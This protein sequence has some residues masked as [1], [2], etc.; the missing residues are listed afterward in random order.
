MGL[1]KNSVARTSQVLLKQKL[2]RIRTN[3]HTADDSVRQAGDKLDAHKILTRRIPPRAAIF[4]QPP[5]R[6]QPADAPS[7]EATSNPA[8][9]EANCLNTYKPPPKT[10]GSWFQASCRQLQTS[11]RHGQANF[12]RGCEPHM[13]YL[14]S[15][16]RNLFA[17]GPGVPQT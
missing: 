17:G 5:P 10:L 11:R 16:L 3:C 6:T 9:P 14:L 2:Q 15:Q 1:H 4:L 12:G 8:G 7:S 13:T